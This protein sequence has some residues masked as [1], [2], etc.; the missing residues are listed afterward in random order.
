MTDGAGKMLIF[1]RWVVLAMAVAVQFLLPFPLI[2]YSQEAQAPARKYTISRSGVIEQDETWSGTVHVTGP[3]TVS[4]GVT[5]TIEPGT[6]VEFKHGNLGSEDCC[7]E[8]LLFD[9]SCEGPFH[10]K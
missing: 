3:T 5:L 9:F 2:A 6:V 10:R 1:R 4:E 8:Q 7:P